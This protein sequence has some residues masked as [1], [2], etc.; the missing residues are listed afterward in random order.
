MKN[1]I[2]VS[3]FLVVMMIMTPAMLTAKPMPFQKEKANAAASVANL[4]V[5]NLGDKGDYLYL[6]IDLSQAG[7]GL[8]ML[9]I[10]DLIGE[11]LFSETISSKNYRRIFKVSP[12]EF[13]TIQIE[14][15]T[16]D[17]TVRKKFNLSTITSK[18]TNLVETTD[19]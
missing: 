12:E 1:V 13:P 16:P 9:R 10:Y 6:Q 15:F 19:K 2:A 5:I 4:E 3:S 18:S 8:S 14:Y 17:G 11:G 7:N